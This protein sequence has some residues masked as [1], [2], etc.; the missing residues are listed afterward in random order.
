MHT[1]SQ[2]FTWIRAAGLRS[3][4]AALLA[5]LADAQALAA[6]LEATYSQ[7]AG[8]GLRCSL[9]GAAG[10]RST[11]RRRR[12]CCAEAQATSSRLH[13]ACLLQCCLLSAAP[14]AKP[15]LE[16]ILSTL[17]RDLLPPQPQLPDETLLQAH[18]TGAAAAFGGGAQQ[19]QALLACVGRC[20][21][22]YAPAAASSEEL[23]EAYSLLQVRALRSCLQQ[24]ARVQTCSTRS[25]C[26]CC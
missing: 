25:F 20:P 8:A 22:G 12:S 13:A 7:G 15:V 24:G 17:D 14:C 2:A 5:G 19:A 23:V 9:G 4:S 18:A 26:M 16:V 21:A 6:V 11:A 1:A 3:V 10:Q